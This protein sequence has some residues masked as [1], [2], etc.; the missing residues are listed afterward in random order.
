MAIIAVVHHV[1]IFSIGLKR[2]CNR[3]GN[4]LNQLIPVK[5]LGKLRWFQGCPDSRNR[6]RGTLK[7]SQKQFADELA[8]KFNKFQSRFFRV[9]RKTRGV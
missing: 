7:I 8:R 6:E 2:R 3:I 4:E 9:E 1:D 5:N